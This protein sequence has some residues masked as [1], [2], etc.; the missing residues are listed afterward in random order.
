MIVGSVCRTIFVANLMV[1]V[2]QGSIQRI[3]ALTITGFWT[4]PPT[5]YAKVR[6][7]LNAPP[8]PAV[9]VRIFY[10]SYPENVVHFHQLSPLFL[11]NL[12]LGNRDVHE[13][14]TTRDLIK[15]IIMK[16]IFGTTHTSGNNII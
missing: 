6:F 15:M 4:N 14:S 5:L 13:F 9:R 12:R 2:P 10:D 8:P 3:H 16:V 11:I 7:L 1:S